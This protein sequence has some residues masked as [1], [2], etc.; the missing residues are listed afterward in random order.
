[1]GVVPRS[2]VMTYREQPKGTREIARE[3][4][5]DAVIEATVF[6]DGDRMR[7]TVQM[8]EPESLRLLWSE[9][10]ERDVSDVL[11]AQ[12]EI[13]EQITTDLGSELTGVQDNAGA[14]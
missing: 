13:A 5:V 4:S 8:T 10:Y 6:R 12:R 7:I 3:L 11:S 1:M 9:G 2:A 14:P